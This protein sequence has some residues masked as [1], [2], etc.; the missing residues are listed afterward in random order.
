MTEWRLRGRLKESLKIPSKQAYGAWRT[1]ER[2]GKY[3]GSCL[4]CAESG[5]SWGRGLEATKDDDSKQ[6]ATEQEEGGRRNTLSRI[7]YDLGA[8][9]CLLLS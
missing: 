3:L 8:P 5:R 9:L 6:D 1:K 4:G 7:L 2:K